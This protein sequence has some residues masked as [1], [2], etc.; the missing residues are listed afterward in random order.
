M[1]R[2]ILSTVDSTNKYVEEHKAN[3]PLP[4]L[5]TAT[6]QRSGKGQGMNKWDSKTGDILF[7]LYSGLGGISAGSFFTISQIVSLA[8]VRF[9][10]SCNIVACIKWPNDILV[11]E[12][13]ICGILIK[14]YIQSGVLLSAAMGVGLNVIRRGKSPSHYNPPA[15][16]ILQHAPFSQI[17]S[18]TASEEIA[19]DILEVIDNYS[20]HTATQIRAEYWQNLYRNQ[21]FFP[22]VVRGESCM[23]RLLAVC[24]NGQLHLQDKKGT[25]YVCTFQDVQYVL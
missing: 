22:F 23:A 25:E 24:D 17:N 4:T 7:T 18:N 1:H 15:T 21:G 6:Q 9:L 12:Q 14:T 20:P 10:R 5:V 2:I 16:S 8:I 13:K 3:F 11:E 19:R